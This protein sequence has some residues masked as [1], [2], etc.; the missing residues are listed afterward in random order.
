MPDH[1]CE[2]CG[3]IFASKTDLSR[4]KDK[5][6]P[7]IYVENIAKILNNSNK[8]NNFIFEEVKN[9]KA[10]EETLLYNTELKRLQD[11]LKD[12]IYL[13][14]F[15]ALE[16][17]IKFKKFYEDTVSKLFLKLFSL[18]Q[19]KIIKTGDKEEYKR[20]WDLL[21]NGKVK[22]NDLVKKKLI[23]IFKENELYF[24]KRLFKYAKN[25]M[26]ELYDVKYIDLSE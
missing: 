19:R 1:T 21:D 12:E 6:N 16:T 10:D 9:V 23:G 20:D 26:M 14:V 22:S 3:K 8:N 5:K 4:H 13:Y 15:N 11:E 17:N 7:C 18:C 25:I 2:K 24:N